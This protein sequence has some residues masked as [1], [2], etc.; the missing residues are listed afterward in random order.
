VLKG[1][2]Q[3]IGVVVLGAVGMACIQTIKDNME[4]PGSSTL[5]ENINKQFSVF[6]VPPGPGGAGTPRYGAPGYGSGGGYGSPSGGRPNNVY[7]GQPGYGQPYD[8]LPA[9]GGVPGQLG[10]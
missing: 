7:P 1:A 4:Q 8:S 10:R 2:S 3:I 6:Q 5:P 9:D